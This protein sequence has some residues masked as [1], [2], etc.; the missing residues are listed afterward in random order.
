MD[1]LQA[2]LVTCLIEI[3][4]K[5]FADLFV[6]Y[7]THFQNKRYFLQSIWFLLTA[8]VIYFYFA[9]FTYCLN[10]GLNAFKMQ[11]IITQ[12][13]SHFL[14]TN[15]HTHNLTL[16]LW[17]NCINSSKVINNIGFCLWCTINIKHLAN[18]YTHTNTSRDYTISDLL[19]Y[20]YNK[21]NV[22]SV[23]LFIAFSD[24]RNSPRTE[25]KQHHLCR[26]NKW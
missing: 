11:Y 4:P 13:Q 10:H 16:Y 3:I 20:N 15:T 8:S 1:M 18:T 14:Q 26:W 17:N 7:C 24:L 5:R 21:Y 19:I 6:F 23:W 9:V 25:D 2:T 22:R 12:H